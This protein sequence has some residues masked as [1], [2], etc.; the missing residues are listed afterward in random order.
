M[1]RLPVLLALL[2]LACGPKPGGGAKDGGGT[3]GAP[4]D[5]GGGGDA[6]DD[7][8]TGPDAGPDAGPTFDGGAAAIRIATGNLSSGNGQS[9]DPGEGIR[10]FQGL[11]PDIAMVQEM[12][13]GGGADAD[14]RAFVDSAFGTAYGYFRESGAQ[15]PNGVVSRFPILESGS[16][17]DPQVSNRSFV[18]ARLDVPGPVDLWAVSVHLLTSGSAARNSEAQALV[19]Q[20]QTVVPAGAYVVVGGDF[21]TDTRTESCLTTLAA[22]V[23]TGAPYPSDQAGNQNTNASR[24]KPYDWVAVS[25]SL[26]VRQV[27][28][29]I[30]VAHFADGLVFDSRVYTPL[31]DV[32]PVLQGDSGAS[33]MQHMAVVKDFVIPE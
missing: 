29:T 31:A 24:A 26:A 5:G 18:W 10:I 12:N 32:A 30:G 22:A 21:N 25:S 9:Y 27:P 16:W 1:T 14:L 3:D 33:N 7:G 13:Y 6:G 17:T 15:I 19:Q 28:V 23:Q 4:G 11:H 8:G 20:L 2:S